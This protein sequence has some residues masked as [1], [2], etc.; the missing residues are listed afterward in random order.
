[1]S[2]RDTAECLH[3]Y[4]KTDDEAVVLRGML[5]EGPESVFE[6]GEL[7]PDTLEDLMKVRRDSGLT[8]QCLCLAVQ[9]AGE[10]RTSVTEAMAQTVFVRI[11]DRGRGYRNLRV[12]RDELRRILDGFHDM[13]EVG[14]NRGILSLEYVG[15]SGHR[16]DRFYMVEYDALEYRGRVMFEE[17]Y[18]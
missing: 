11:Y 1:M 7:T 4:L 2:G 16:W 3:N 5:V 8:D 17:G 12:A 15:R 9:D 18:G 10:V 6:S 14:T 13:L